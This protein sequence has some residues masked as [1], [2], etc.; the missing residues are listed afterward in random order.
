[1]LHWFA[2]L[3]R[4]ELLFHPDDDPAEITS[5]VDGA[6]T[7]S[8]VEVKELR[9]VLDKMFAMNGDRVYDAAYPVFMKRMGLRLDS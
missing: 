1:M 9:K 7:F 6:V 2:E 4:Q 8:V 3:S 5:V